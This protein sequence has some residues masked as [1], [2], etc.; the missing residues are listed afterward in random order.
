MT[1]DLPDPRG[2][3]S[4]WADLA[5]GVSAGDRGSEEEFVRIFYPNV[6]AM[7]A[8]RM[9]DYEAARELAQEILMNVV[10]GLRRGLVREPG[11]LP[12]FVIGTA[13]N[14]IKHRLQEMVLRP[15]AVPFDPNADPSASKDRSLSP[16]ES[17]VE[18]EE[19]RA[20]AHQVLQRLK[21]MDRRILYLT[22]A[23][24]LTPREIAV[25]VGLKPENVRNR[26]SR[27]LKVLQSK[28]A[29]LIRNSRPLH[30]NQER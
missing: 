27:A 10:Q 18:E 13:R 11:K 15:A 30:Y 28:M 29:R 5:R 9:R 21:P 7:A 4:R 17:D 23:E 14:L 12:A 2:P 3:A 20:L 24:G 1:D 19:R 26:K 25:E 8:S 22:L 16:Q 6:M